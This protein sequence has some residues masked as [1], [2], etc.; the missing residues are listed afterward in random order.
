MPIMRAA[1]GEAWHRE[2]IVG[3]INLL[4]AKARKAG[5]PVIWVQHSDPYM[6][7]GKEPWEIV[8]ELQ[9]LSTEPNVR[10]KF[11]SS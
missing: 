2:E 10:K 11:R 9:P 8:P 7:I 3:N 4:V 5:T 6:E 1:V